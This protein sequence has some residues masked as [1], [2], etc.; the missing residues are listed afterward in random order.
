MALLRVTASLDFLVEMPDCACED[1]YTSDSQ[2]ARDLAA[3]RLLGFLPSGLGSVAKSGTLATR[4]GLWSE[5]SF[6][7]RAWDITE[8]R[9]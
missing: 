8:R 1:L 7:C 9:P 2:L 6:S 3:D 4:A 5:E